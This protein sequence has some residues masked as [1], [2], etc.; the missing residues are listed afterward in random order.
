MIIII[1]GNPVAWLVTDKEDVTTMECFLQAVKSR[2]PT[3]P[4]HV[5]MTDDGED[6]EYIKV[7]IKHVVMFHH[8]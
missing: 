7:L 1:S 4:I 2:S 8:R 6:S 5:A 3:V